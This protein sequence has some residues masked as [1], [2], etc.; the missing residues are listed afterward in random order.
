MAPPQSGPGSPT[1][2]EE[3]RGAKITFARQSSFNRATD[4]KAN[5][6]DV[7]DFQVPAYA[8]RPPPYLRNGGWWGAITI[9]AG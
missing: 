5:L 2:E 1:G 7:T 8:P 3:M 6:S 4:M 9:L